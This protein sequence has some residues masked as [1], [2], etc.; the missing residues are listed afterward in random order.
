MLSER[1]TET[2][3]LGRNR[4]AVVAAVTRTPKPFWFG[5]EGTMMV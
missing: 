1:L 2:Q 3:C 4:V 5:F